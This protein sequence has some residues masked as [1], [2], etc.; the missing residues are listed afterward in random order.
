MRN[1]FVYSWFDDH[2]H[3][4]SLK[5]KLNKF[6]KY[7][8]SNTGGKHIQIYAKYFALRVIELWINGVMVF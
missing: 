2:T 8:Q 5:E 4:F 3:T 1:H 6:E 7:G